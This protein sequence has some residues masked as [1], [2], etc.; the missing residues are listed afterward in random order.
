MLRSSA[1]CPREILLY[2]LK[3]D[4]LTDQFQSL[5]Q[6]WAEPLVR[7]RRLPCR[8]GGVWPSHLCADRDS[9]THTGN[10]KSNHAF[11]TCL[12]VFSHKTFLV[13]HTE[14][15]RHSGLSEL[16]RHQQRDTLQR[17][18][19]KHSSGSTS[20]AKCQLLS[21]HVFS[22]QGADLLIKCQHSGWQQF[23]KCVNL[24]FIFFC[25]VK[26][27]FSS[28]LGPPDCALRNY[29][30]LRARPSLHWFQ[31]RNRTKSPKW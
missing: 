14:G 21:G 23:E 30:S 5:R 22:T 3:F 31:S 19:K 9:H 10:H 16:L 28:L 11:F 26:N 1:M 20:T 12:P 25:V 2:V 7:V 15:M 29:V 27:R 4:Q 17:K 13:L 8:R 18:K 24:H 6:N